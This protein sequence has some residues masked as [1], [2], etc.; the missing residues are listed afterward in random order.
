MNNAAKH[1]K[2]DRI[3]VSLIGEDGTIQLI[4]EDNG[5]GF[6]VE[7][8]HSKAGPKGLGLGSM[9]E[10]VE[11]SGGEFTIESATGKGTTIRAELARDIISI[12]M[13]LVRLSGYIFAGLNR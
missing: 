13:T 4:I 1:S 11:L 12:R 7:E 2:A 9:R 8:H 5:Q 10:R 6:N 3:R